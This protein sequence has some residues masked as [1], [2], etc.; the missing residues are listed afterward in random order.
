MS[1]LFQSA[2]CRFLNIYQKQEQPPHE[3]QC[4][5]LSPSNG[6]LLSKKRIRSCHESLFVSLSLCL[7]R[8]VFFFPN[9]SYGIPWQHCGDRKRDAGAKQE[10]LSSFFDRYFRVYT[11]ETSGFTLKEI[12]PKKSV[13]I[14]RNI[15]NVLQYFI[16][17]I[18]RWQTHD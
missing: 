12:P 6:S 5:A 1:I 10:Q 18:S 16:L 4:H 14:L 15:R 9:G 2:I 17:Y 8:R 7:F 13:Y 11:W 3:L